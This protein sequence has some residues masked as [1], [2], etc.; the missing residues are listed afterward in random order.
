M[1]NYSKSLLF[2]CYFIFRESQNN[3]N[4]GE[5]NGDSEEIDIESNRERTKLDVNRIM[6]KLDALDEGNPVVEV[7]GNLFRFRIQVYVLV[8]FFVFN[9][10]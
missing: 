4:L 9:A 7:P 6:D 5:T 1:T 3:T 2:E 8:Y 10:D